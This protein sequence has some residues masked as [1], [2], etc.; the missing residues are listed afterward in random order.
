MFRPDMPLLSI[1]APAALATIALL[2]LSGRIDPHRMY[3][4]VELWPIALITL[5]LESFRRRR[6]LNQGAILITVGSGG[7]LLH[8]LFSTD[9]LSGLAWVLMVIGVGLVFSALRRGPGGTA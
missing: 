9:A 2:V 1:V 6:S 3:A 5:G 4:V 8:V 7:A